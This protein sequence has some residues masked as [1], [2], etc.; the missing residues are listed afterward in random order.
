MFFTN[1]SILLVLSAVV[2]NAV[3]QRAYISTRVLHQLISLSAGLIDTLTSD[4]GSVATQIGTGAESVFTQVTGGAGSVGT[5]I[6]SGAQGVFE[7]VTS[8]G[9]TAFTIV[10]SAGGEA[11]TLAASGAGKVTSFA[12][13]QYT[14]ATGAVLPQNSAALPSAMLSSTV[15]VGL[16]TVFT[17]VCVGALITV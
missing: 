12:G 7:T 11:I 1:K 9:G 4:V 14:I 6:A 16:F 8:A 2:V 15:L 17:S 5:V 13:S 10:T 3:P